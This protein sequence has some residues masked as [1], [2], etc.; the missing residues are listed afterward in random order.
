[1]QMEI[2]PLVET[3]RNRFVTVAILC[4]WE[5]RNTMLVPCKQHEAVAQYNGRQRRD[6]TA[7]FPPAAVLIRWG[8]VLSGEGYYVV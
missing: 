1:M 4:G 6:R 2:L 7:R 5:Q 8:G 3:E